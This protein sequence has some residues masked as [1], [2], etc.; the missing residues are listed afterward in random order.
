MTKHEANE[1]LDKIR[2]GYL[3]PSS[4]T[5]ITKLLHITG[6]LGTHARLRSE[7]VD[8][9]VQ[10][11]DWRARVRERAILVGRSKERH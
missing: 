10:S 5:F 3:H 7:R 1:I 8:N 2:S 11:E 9:E 6:D 4:A